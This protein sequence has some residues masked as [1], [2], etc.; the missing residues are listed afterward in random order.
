MKLPRTGLIFIPVMIILLAQM[1]CTVRIIMRASPT[2]PPSPIVPTNTPIPPTLT[3]T[4]TVTPIP[5]TST[6][7]E[8]STTPTDT[9]TATPEPVVYFFPVQPPSVTSY[10]DGHHDYPAVD[11]FAP[12]GS[13]FVAVT[14]GIIDFVSD[15][16]RYNFD[17]DDPATRGGLCVAIIGDDGVRYYGSHLSE[18]APGIA[19]GK[20]VTAGELLGYTG[21]SGNARGLPH[22]HFGISHPTTPD[23]WAVRRGEIN[24]Y[25]Y[26]QAWQNGIMLAPD[27]AKP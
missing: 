22:L 13:E 16:D 21:D 20:R 26:L 19:V 6:P 15:T 1:A 12:T 27:L 2:P 3:E 25:P 14:D 17:D 11:I 4:A 18:L 23:D 24:P 5:P 8:P 7:T 9:P 10:A